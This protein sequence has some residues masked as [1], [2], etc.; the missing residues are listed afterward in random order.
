VFPAHSATVDQLLADRILGN[1]DAKVTIVEY[2]SLT[3]PHCSSFHRDTLPAI[4]ETYVV[5]GKVRI[6][7]RDFP[8]GGL[9]A[10]AAMVSRCVPPERYFGFLDVLFALQANW[11][12]SREPLKELAL[13]ARQAGLSQEAFDACLNNRDLLQGIQSRS[14]AA[15][16]EKGIESTPTF[17]VNDRKIVGAPRLE[18]LKAVIDEELAKSR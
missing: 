12:T 11:S 8:F 1:A 16:R 4:K 13:L 7:Y 3:C 2:S 17:F 5:P 14:Q 10:A 18:D 6:I 9:A 15:Q